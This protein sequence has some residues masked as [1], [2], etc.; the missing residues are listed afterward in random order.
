M[1][2]H[3]AWTPPWNP[4]RHPTWL[5]SE[6]GGTWGARSGGVKP[7]PHCWDPHGTAVTVPVGREAPC[8]AGDPLHPWHCGA[9]PGYGGNPHRSGKTRMEPGQP[10]VSRSFKPFFQPP[11]PCRGTGLRQRV[12]IPTQQLVCS[13]HPWGTNPAQLFWA[14]RAIPIIPSIPR[15]P[16]IPLPF[17]Q[18]IPGPLRHARL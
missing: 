16:D 10:C 9:S 6:P 18:V 12:Q 17:S 11:A 4:P 15:S 7:H 13:F 1:R 2:W 8:P 14:G 3:R 5:H